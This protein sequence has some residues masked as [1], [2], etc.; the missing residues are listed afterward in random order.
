MFESIKIVHFTTYLMFFFVQK[1]LPRLLFFDYFTYF[2]STYSFKNILWV[3]NLGSQA[4]FCTKRLNYLSVQTFFFYL[5]RKASKLQKKLHFSQRG[6]NKMHT[7]EAK[8]CE[9]KASEWGGEKGRD[10]RAKIGWWHGGISRLPRGEITTQR[11][12]SHVTFLRDKS[13]WSP[14]YQVRECRGQASISSRFS[15][16]NCVWSEYVWEPGSRSRNRGPAAYA[17]PFKRPG[18]NTL[19]QSRLTGCRATPLLPPR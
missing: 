2:P 8:E 4:S 17:A 9:Q 11:L 5:W 10:T 1:R 14:G 3:S 6:K 7:Q 18:E 12:G 15:K 13:S 19:A 16:R